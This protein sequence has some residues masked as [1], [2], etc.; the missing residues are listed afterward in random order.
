M[1]TYCTGRSTRSC[2]VPSWSQIS[3]IGRFITPRYSISFGN[4]MDVSVA[5]FVSY[6]FGIAFFAINAYWIAIVTIPGY[7]PF[8]FRPRSRHTPLKPNCP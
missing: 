5:Y 1:C 8:I 7:F 4:Q 3:R 2:K 6:L